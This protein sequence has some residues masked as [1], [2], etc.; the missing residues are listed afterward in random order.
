MKPNKIYA[1]LLSALLLTG[2]IENDVPYPIIECAIDSIAA[3]GLAGTPAYDR[4]N[5]TVTL[6][7]VDTTDIQAVNITYASTT[8]DARTSIPIVGVQNL[9][10]PMIVNLTLYQNYEWRIEANQ[11]ITR[12]FRVE[13]QVGAT[14]W[15]MENKTARV[16]VS[17]EDLWNISIKTLKLGPAGITRMIWQSTELSDTNLYVLH[18]FSEGDR[19]IDVTCHG[20]T[21]TWW[22]HVEHTDAKVAF[23][24]IDGWS[25]TAWI[26]ASGE[27]GSTMGFSYRASGS[28]TWIEVPA[29]DIEI[30]GGAFQT[31]LSGLEPE[32]VYEV[33]A[34]SGSDTTAVEKFMTERT[35]PL[36]NAGF[37][38]WA[39]LSDGILHPYLSSD[40]AFWDTGNKG[41]KAANAII[42]QGSPDI[43]PGSS[44]ST[45][46]E[47][48]SLFANLAGIGKFAAG[49]IF[50][51][52]YA[53]TVG[54]NGK[55]NFGRPFTARPTALHGWI[56]YTQG[57]IDRIGDQQ[58][59]GMT[60]QKGDK[61]QGSIYIAVG[62]WT[63]EEYG[64]TA[65][66]PVQI[67]TADVKT[68]FN[69][70]APAVIG[71]GEW[72]I[73]ESINEWREFTIPLEYRSTN[74]KP[75]HLIIV[76]SASRWGDYFTGSTQSR[77]WLDDIE[78]QW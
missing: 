56:K 38:D 33:I 50:I 20:R 72:M 46:A 31:R 42:S 58:P 55:V 71:Y 3:D 41:A 15:D 44:G 75:T 30:D 8:N 74:E 53:E 4:I 35:L 13:S 47:L 76:C 48:T 73:D 36:P 65:E 7:L 70:K 11:T 5:R 64:G 67:Y 40:D 24:Q 2:C 34:Y 63:P 16:K 25:K 18:D 45:S 1:L 19:R 28:D 57:T 37:E 54:T 78:L 12:E 66:S 49:N 62:T 26:Y 9:S 43:R 29:D 22:L 60:L 51:G 77:M 32:S 59:Q 10:T 21:E 17:T 23:T 61:D 39:T 52:T 14:E 6:P 69:S 27:S 68:F